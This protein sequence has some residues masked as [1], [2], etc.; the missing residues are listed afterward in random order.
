MIAVHPHVCGDNYTG[1][2]HLRWFVGSPPRV[3]GQRTLLSRNSDKRWFTPTCVGTT[4]QAT[5]TRSMASVHPHVCGDNVTDC[6]RLHISRGSPPR[7]WGQPRRIVLRGLRS[8][9]T[10]TCVG[11]TKTCSCDRVG[12]SVHP[13]VCGDNVSA[14]IVQFVVIGS[15]PRVWGQHAVCSSA[16]LHWRFTPTCV[17]TTSL[18]SMFSRCSSVHPHVCGDNAAVEAAR[19][20]TAVHPHVCGDNDLITTGE[21]GEIGS[22]PRVWGQRYQF[23]TAQQ[24]CRFTPTCVG[25][26]IT[27]GERQCVIAVHPHVCGDN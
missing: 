12:R 1:R 24:S 22:P 15:P 4:S 10:P 8:R 19:L 26:T 2:S 23:H 9:F 3:W 13:H 25:T 7:V 14:S 18:K 27:R 16:D 5:R 6:N 21:A 11:T 17:G 20:T